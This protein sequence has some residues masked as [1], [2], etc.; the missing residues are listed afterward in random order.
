MPSL[1]DLVL[2]IIGPIAWLII[3]FGVIS[4][5][6]NDVTLRRLTKAS[7]NINNLSIIDLILAYFIGM[8]SFLFIY[9]YCY[10]PQESISCTGSSTSI[11]IFGLLL[12]FCGRII[13][14]KQ[15]VF[16]GKL[17]FSMIFISSAVLLI[18]NT[19]IQCKLTFSDFGSNFGIATMEKIFNQSYI[20]SV[21]YLQL[22]YSSGNSWL[23]SLFFV[24][25]AGSL[26]LAIMGEA[27][28]ASTGPSPKSLLAVA[29]KFPSDFRV[30]TGISGER[31]NI[32]KLLKEIFD[33]NI[34]VKIK[35]VTKSLVFV[36]LIGNHIIGQAITHPEIQFNYRILKSPKNRALDDRMNALLNLPFSL[37][38]SLKNREGLYREF[39]HE[40]NIR[41]AFLNELRQHYNVKAYNYYFGET[42]FLVMENAS[43]IQKL[44]FLVKDK[45]NINNRVGLYT[46]S[47]Y[48][49]DMFSMLFENAWDL[50]EKNDNNDSFNEI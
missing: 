14:K 50:L 4:G 20:L 19:I 47:P 38:N 43:G 25:F 1:I 49:I 17:H 22:L 31:D 10:N 24:S 26:V 23:D 27:Y 18:F 11:A 28:L 30:I 42:M 48:I 37:T 2:D 16:F 8:I 12:L 33:D 32:Q 41:D 34:I 6:L 13:T 40:Y 5:F 3:I 46:E 35:C 29:E 7:F 44:L 36:D 15:G 9:Y 21:D 45:G 39:K